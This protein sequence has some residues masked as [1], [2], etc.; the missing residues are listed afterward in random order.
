MMSRLHREPNRALCLLVSKVA[1]SNPARP[2]TFHLN[3]KELKSQLA[4]KEKCGE[5]LEKEWNDY[6]LTGQSGSSQARSKAV[7]LRSH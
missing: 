4:R 1:G 2:T 5:F 6:S 7:D 3:T